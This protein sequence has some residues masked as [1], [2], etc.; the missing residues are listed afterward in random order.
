MQVIFRFILIPIPACVSVFDVSKAA[1]QCLVS[2][3]GND[4]RFD[5]PVSIWLVRFVVMLYIVGKSL[6][7]YTENQKSGLNNAE[8]IGKPPP[9]RNGIIQVRSI[10]RK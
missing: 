7:L 1:M 3:T 4:A 6:R 8:S 9:R 10:H 5:G 2:K